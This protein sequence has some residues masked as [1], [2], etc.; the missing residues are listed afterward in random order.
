M[1]RRELTRAE[2]AAEDAW[3][4]ARGGAWTLAS[5]YL[6]EAV[7]LGFAAS[8]DKSL[9]AVEWAAGAIAELAEKDLE[10]TTPGGCCGPCGDALPPEP[11]A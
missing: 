1:P 7:Q 8:D 9:D 11:V 2:T 4:F 5:M 10:R 6:G 3:R